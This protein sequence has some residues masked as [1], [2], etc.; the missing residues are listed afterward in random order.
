MTVQNLAEHS[1]KRGF[2]H[3]ASLPTSK[4]LSNT[5]NDPVLCQSGKTGA[6]FI[7]SQRKRREEC[8]PSGENWFNEGHDI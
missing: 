7:H 4:S 2:Q 8:H 6:A 1:R 5:L 3:K